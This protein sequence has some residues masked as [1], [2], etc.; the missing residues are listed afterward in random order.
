MILDIIQAGLTIIG[1]ATLIFRIVAPMTENKYDNEILKWLES[2]T[3]KVSLNR[4]TGKVEIRVI[5]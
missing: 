5:E 2:F 4:D 1:A 3:S